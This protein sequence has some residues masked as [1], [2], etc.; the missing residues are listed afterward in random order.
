VPK[1]PTGTSSWENE[2]RRE[3]ALSGV[4]DRGGAGSVPGRGSE[5]GAELSPLEYR[6]LIPPTVIVS[7]SIRRCFVIR[8]LL[9]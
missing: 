3:G 2:R 4:V 8:L 5:E 9:T 1:A 7:F 6:R